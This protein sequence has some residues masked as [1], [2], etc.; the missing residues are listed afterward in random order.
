MIK[1]NFLFTVIG[2]LIGFFNREHSIKTLLHGD[3]E[4]KGFGKTFVT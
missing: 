3:R 2:S 4:T 1:L